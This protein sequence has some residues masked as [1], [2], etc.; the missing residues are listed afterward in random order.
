MRQGPLAAALVAAAISALA[1]AVVVNAGS[2]S[3]SAK[4]KDSLFAALAGKNEIG[5]DGKKGAG[6]RD[7]R[8][9]FSATVDGGE[10][11]F[12][13]VVKS[14]M[15]P[16]AA[17]IHKGTAAKAGP[18]VIPLTAPDSGDPGTAAGCVTPEDSGLLRS[19]LKNP[20]RYYVNVHTADFPGGA[21]RGQL[22]AKSP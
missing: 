21:V 15:K 9:S 4:A 2:G 19:I 3:T 1:V 22:F 6:D 18:V 13:L 20:A 17:H 7:G 10:I 14:I 16:V 8:G 12:G 11:C 5:S